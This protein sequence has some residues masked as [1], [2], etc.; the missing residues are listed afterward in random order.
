LIQG[1]LEVEQAKLRKELDR[2]KKM[3]NLGF[4][5]EVVWLPGVIKFSREDKA[6]RGEVLGNKI[7]LYDEDLDDAKE[8]LKHEFIEYLMDQAVKPYRN[9]VNN[10]I[11]FF[12][13]QAYSE[14]EKTVK[15][16]TNLFGLLS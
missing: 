3:A 12:Q 8:T 10:W 14:R 13:D 11:S 5:L 6:L 1:Q 2:L 15:A 4:E 9:L 16:L 7:I